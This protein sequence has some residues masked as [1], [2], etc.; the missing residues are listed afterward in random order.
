MGQELPLNLLGTVHGM[1]YRR[2]VYEEGI[3]NGLDDV[4]MML[5]DRLADNLIVYLQQPQHAGFVS[6]HLATEADDVGEHDR[7][8]PPCLCG[9]RAGIALCHGGDYRA[10][11]PQLSNRC[12]F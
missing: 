9:L 8:Q 11:G 7:G 4:T 3:P 5:G 10:G 6:P 1:N 2:E 12:V